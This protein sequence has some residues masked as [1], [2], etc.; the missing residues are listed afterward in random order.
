[1][2]LDSSVSVTVTQPQRLHPNKS[3]G[4]LG[5]GDDVMSLV[6][7]TLLSPSPCV[8]GVTQPRGRSRGGSQGTI[9]ANLVSNDFVSTFTPMQPVHRA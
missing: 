4:L 7:N 6:E 9:L 5:L 3:G 2:Q 8:A 1:M